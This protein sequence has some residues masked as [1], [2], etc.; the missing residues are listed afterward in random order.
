M[1]YE[2]VTPTMRRLLGYFM[3]LRNMGFPSENLYCQ[4]AKSG[5]APGN[6]LSAFLVVR[7]NGREF[8][9]ECGPVPSEEEA[10]EQ[11][12]YLA[13]HAQE[14][15]DQKDADRIYKECDAVR[16]AASFTLALMGKGLWPR[17]QS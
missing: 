13:M 7:E 15:L 6:P 5:L 17:Q 12:L 10:H 3:C 14:E 9:C 4:V 8:A 11:W 16:G 1:R 2:D